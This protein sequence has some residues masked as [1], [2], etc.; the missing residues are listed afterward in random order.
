MLEREQSA[1]SEEKSIDGSQERA[2]VS[3][4]ELSKVY[5]QG[6]IEVWALNKVDLVISEGGFVSICGP[7]G[8]GKSTLLNLIGGLDT[9]TSGKV[10]IA[11]KRLDKMSDS[12]RSNLRLHEIG[13]VFQAY[14]LVP[15]LTAVENVAFVMQLQGVE[16]AERTARA[17]DVL[18]EVGLGS[19]GN[20]RPAELS[21]G[22]QQRVAVARA[23]VGNPKIVLADEPTANLDSDNAKA[24]LEVM[25]KMNRERDVSFIFSTHDPLVV[26]YAERVVT[27]HDGRI[28]GDVKK[29]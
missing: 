26:D 1:E 23:I 20:R 27:L 22:Q 13:F 2:R 21:G 19:L 8:S 5:V 7:S 11:G 4:S 24:L 25:R 16:K 17:E 15:V 10:T 9:P 29:G 12:E 28:T 6:E 14:N 3:V 18:R